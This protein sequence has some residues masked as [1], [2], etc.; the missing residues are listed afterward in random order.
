MTFREVAPDGSTIIS[1]GNAPIAADSLILPP[2]LRGGRKERIIDLNTDPEAIQPGFWA[3]MPGSSNLPPSSAGAYYYGW[4]VIHDA[5]TDPNARWLTQYAQSFSGGPTILQHA[6]TWFRRKTSTGWQAWRTLEVLPI[7]H[8]GTYT[9]RSQNA[10]NDGAERTVHPVHDYGA[11]PA[12][13]IWAEIHMSVS[14]NCF[15]NA[16]CWW[17][18]H[19]RRGDAANN[20]VIP[21]TFYVHNHGN[22]YFDMGRSWTFNLDVRPHVARGHGVQLALNC[23]NDPGSGAWLDIGAMHSTITYMGHSEGVY[24]YG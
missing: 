19:L 1:G 5:L 2:N 8:N 4:T 14:A 12:N 6:Q 10:P 17:K 20:W 22:A 15:S 13:A 21:G 23:S 24:M 3:A 7:L 11:P 18:P 9:Y 16:Q